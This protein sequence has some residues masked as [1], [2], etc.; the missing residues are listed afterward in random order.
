[1]PIGYARLSTSDQNL[2]LETDALEAAAAERVFTDTAPG[3]RIDRLG[4]NEVLCSVREEGTV[5]I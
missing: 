1:M 3:A 2:D 5:I 4:M